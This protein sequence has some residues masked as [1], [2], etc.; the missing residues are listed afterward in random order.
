MVEVRIDNELVVQ[1]VCELTVAEGVGRFGGAGAF[2]A[3]VWEESLLLAASSALFFAAS[4]FS[5]LFLVS[6][7]ALSS[8]IKAVI[9]SLLADYFLSAARCSLRRK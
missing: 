8:R 9:S 7:A 3:T 5:T 1:G 4:V 6:T 2:S